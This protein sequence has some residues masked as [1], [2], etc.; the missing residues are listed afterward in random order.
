MNLGEELFLICHDLREGVGD[1]AS[2]LVREAGS[3]ELIEQRGHMLKTRRRYIRR[4]G[5][6]IRYDN[7][8]RC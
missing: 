8:L 7:A 2:V 5:R 3:H 1:R 6:G 4:S